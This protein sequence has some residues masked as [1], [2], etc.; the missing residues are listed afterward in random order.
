MTILEIAIRP[1]KK[2]FLCGQKKYRSGKKRFLYEQKN[3]FVRAN[4]YK[5]IYFSYGRFINTATRY[6]AILADQDDIKVIAEFLKSRFLNHHFYTL[7]E[8]E[9]ES[10]VE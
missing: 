8:R 6:M 2:D 1:N 9:R 10:S 7:R 4:S 5:Y 3:F